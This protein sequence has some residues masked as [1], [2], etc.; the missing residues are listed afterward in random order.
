MLP[1][2]KINFELINFI[3]CLCNS[4]VVTFV[5]LSIILIGVLHFDMSFRNVYWFILSAS[6]IK[7]SNFQLTTV[8]IYLWLVT[9][10]KTSK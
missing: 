1:K 7:I 6:V 2:I 9:D 5:V 10:V 8:R 3:I 4:I